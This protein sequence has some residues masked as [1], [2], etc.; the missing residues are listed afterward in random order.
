MIDRY[1]LGG[2]SIQCARGSVTSTFH[3]ASRKDAATMQ[4]DPIRKK[5]LDNMSIVMKLRHWAKPDKFGK[6][7]GR[8][9]DFAEAADEIERLHAIED[10]AI[11]LIE[12]IRERGSHD[13]WKRL[14]SALTAPRTAESGGEKRSGDDAAE[15]ERRLQSFRS[16]KQ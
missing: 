3:H 6:R 14:A 5:E 7:E 16:E 9:D 8:A 11:D 10:C 4:A 1:S 2:N 15:F 13:N 12:N